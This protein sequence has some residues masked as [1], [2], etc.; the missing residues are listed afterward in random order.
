[1]TVRA[2]APRATVVGIGLASALVPLNSTMIAVGL[3]SV[4]DDFGITTAD[5]RLL[6]TIYLAAMLV[7]QPIAG[8]I[9]DKA[10]AKRTTYVALAGFGAGCVAAGLAPGFGWLVAARA[11]QAVFAAA[12]SPSVQSMLRAVTGPGERGR[13]FGILGSVI[14]AG[15]VLGPLLGG[16]LVDS[17]DWE[18]IFW[19]N[20][21]LIAVCA[22]ALR[23]VH[24]PATTARDATQVPAAPAPDAPGS[25]PRGE[26]AGHGTWSPLFSAAFATQA[27]ANFGQYGLLLLCPLVL[28]AR[29]WDATS[30]GWV[31]TAMTVGIIVMGPIGGRYGDRHG[32]R[33][34]ILGGLALALVAVVLLAPSGSSVSAAL[35]VLSLGLFGIGLGVATP[36][37]TAAGIESVAPER[38]GVAAGWLSASR[39]VG[40]IVSTV[41]L[42][43]LVNDDGTGTRGML[44]LTVV[45][46]A[47]AICAATVVVRG[48]RNGD[49]VPDGS[50]THPARRAGVRG[51]RPGTAVRVRWPNGDRR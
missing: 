23:R 22:V 11:L 47:A 6:I 25:E 13:A 7:G 45:C 38:T 8:R 50:E 40:S 2:L 10:G 46:L 37:V 26:R 4:A 14:G 28:E 29:D 9:S 44:L 12:L 3:R 31:L 49:G 32:R 41:L 36:G 27:F 17:F 51:S 24:V 1:M 15:V 34:P 35:L 43:L 39:Y 21:P 18:A 20:L 48:G 33:L 16:Y 42:G 19:V 5:A 30:I